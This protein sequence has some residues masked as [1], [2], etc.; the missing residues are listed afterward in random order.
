MIIPF[1]PNDIDLTDMSTEELKSFA[2][3][4]N[5]ALIQRC[6]TDEEKRFDR[7]TMEMF[8]K[9]GKTV[10]AEA[11][12]TAKDPEYREKQK[13]NKSMYNNIKDNQDHAFL[14]HF[15]HSINEQTV[16]NVPLHESQCGRGT[17]NRGAI[18]INARNAGF[19]HALSESYL[20]TDINTI[21]YAQQCAAQAIK[22]VENANNC[23]KELNEFKYG[24][25]SHDFYDD[26]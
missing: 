13:M 20:G 3:Q 14:Y 15:D 18:A 5:S 22:K 25:T 7:M 17:L 4:V 6:G 26:E 9:S 19:L 12:D 24:N 8:N 23:M 10:K 11:H 2:E 16:G 1:N 21:D